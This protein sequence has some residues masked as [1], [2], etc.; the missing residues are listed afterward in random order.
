MQPSLVFV[1]GAKKEEKELEKEQEFKF[2]WQKVAPRESYVK[3]SDWVND[4]PFGI[5]VRNVKCMKCKQWGHINTDRECPMFN[6]SL[7]MTPEAVKGLDSAQLQTLMAEDG[8]RLKQSV[9]ERRPDRGF[10]MVDKKSEQEE[11]KR[12]LTQLSN[13]QKLKLLKKLGLSDGSCESSSGVKK[14]KKK[15]HKHK[16][17]KTVDNGDSTSK[18]EKS[19]KSKRHDSRSPPKRKERRRSNSRSPSRHKDERKRRRHDSSESD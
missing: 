8:Y 10:V 5:C 15:K 12:L 1:L 2:E 4:Q 14:E 13:K 9:S 18:S 17:S 11:M 6:K 19:G 7:E 16:K 3:N